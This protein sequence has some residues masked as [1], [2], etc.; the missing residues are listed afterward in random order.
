MKLAW[1]RTH[2]CK[3]KIK[4]FLGIVSSKETI[5]LFTISILRRTRRCFLE[6]WKQSG[7]R[8]QRVLVVER[9]TGGRLA[10]L[11]IYI[12]IPGAWGYNWDTLSLED[13]NTET[14]SSRLG[15]GRKDL[16]L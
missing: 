8:K 3:I 10:I 4:N 16:A 1:T 2:P 6:W 9:H 13:I 7:G 11:H 12:Y 15:F 14:W 5:F